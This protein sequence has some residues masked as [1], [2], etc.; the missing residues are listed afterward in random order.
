MADKTPAERDAIAK[1]YAEKEYLRFT[2]EQAGINESMLTAAM[3]G[4]G[5]VQLAFW[6]AVGYG[7]YR[8][9]S[10]PKRRRR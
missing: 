6:G 7:A 5:I 8:Y 1:Q 4:V 9:F 10:K 3:V 2:L